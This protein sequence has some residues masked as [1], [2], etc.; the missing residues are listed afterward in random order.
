MKIT[1]AFL[2]DDATTVDGKLN[3]RGGVVSS[4]QVGLNRV[5]TVTLVVITQAGPS[6]TAPKIGIHLINPSG[7]SQAIEVD[8]PTASLSGEIGFAYWPLWIPVEIDGR[9]VVVAACDDSSVSIP[10]LVRGSAV[11]D[12]IPHFG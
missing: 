6:D 9:Y 4:A 5:A 3:V 12:E 2:A 11:D 8:V 1:G 7:D 10:L